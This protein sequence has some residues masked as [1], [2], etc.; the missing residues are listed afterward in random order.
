MKTLF[1]LCL[2]IAGFFSTLTASAQTPTK[3]VLPSTGEKVVLNEGWLARRA[4]EVGE[5]GNRLT[6]QPFQ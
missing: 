3:V 6:L 4:N 1:I 5:D 2:W